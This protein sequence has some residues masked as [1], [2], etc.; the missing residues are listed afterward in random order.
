MK[1]EFLTGWLLISAIATQ[2]G[3]PVLSIEDCRALAIRNNKE[4]LIAGEKKQEAYHQRKAAWHE[5]SA[6]DFGSG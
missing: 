6:E 3:T 1:R 2:A 5:L 4:L